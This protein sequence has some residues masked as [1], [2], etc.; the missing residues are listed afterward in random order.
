[1]SAPPAK[2]ETLDKALELR[3][4]GSFVLRFRV[5]DSIE[6][7]VTFQ[8]RVE[9]LDLKVEL[10]VLLQHLVVKELAEKLP[11]LCE[12]KEGNFELHDYD[13]T[14]VLRFSKI[15]GQGY[16][17]VKFR[18]IHPCDFSDERTRL[19][20]RDGSEVATGDVPVASELSRIAEFFR[21]VADEL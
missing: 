17:G 4:P 8:F 6:D 9:F 14:M 19:G 1:M 16:L 15:E 7:G 20:L 12:S 11:E 5:F 2:L 3:F 10:Q 13:G 18:T 21:H